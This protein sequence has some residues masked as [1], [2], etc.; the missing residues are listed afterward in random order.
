MLPAKPTRLVVIK[1]RHAVCRG[2]QK[3]TATC[4]HVWLW[5]E[6]PAPVSRGIAKETAPSESGAG[7]F[8]CVCRDASSYPSNSFT[9]ADMARPSAWPA[10]FLVATPITLPMS[11]GPLAPVSAMMAFRAAS[12]SSALIC[13]GR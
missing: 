2:W 10:S 8:V 12:S 4:G 9:L 1:P 11:L 3:S 6:K 5:I 7:S 13:L